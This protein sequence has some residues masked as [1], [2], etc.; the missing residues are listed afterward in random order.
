M[1]KKRKKFIRGS[2]VLDPKHLGV[3]NVDL[4]P[5]F[6]I[7]YSPRITKVILRERYPFKVQ[8]QVDIIFFFFSVAHQLDVL[9]AV[10]AGRRRS[11]PPTL[12][13]V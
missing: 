10:S 6:A 2:G 5:S 13:T 4:N 11:K 8:I 1:R 12:D 7:N 3:P 9:H